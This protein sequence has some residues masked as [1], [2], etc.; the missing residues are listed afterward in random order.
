M[1][2]S[3]TADHF[4]TTNYGKTMK[5]YNKFNS[6]FQIRW[7][8]ALG[9]P[10]CPYLY[11]WTLIIF[12]FTI[13]LHHW[14]RSDDNRYF[15]DHAT[16]LISIILKGH[17]YNVIPADDS[18]DTSKCNKILVK[19][20]SVWKAKA[21]Q[22][23]YLEIPEGGA[24]TLL[25]CGRPYNKWGFWVP[26]KDNGVLRKLRPLRYFHEYGVIQDEDYQ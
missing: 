8:E 12:G 19:A 23:H 13:R 5:N 3:I 2:E 17:Y 14:L 10:E 15:H 25:L 11:R 4:I 18:C 22:R 21:E 26:R 6:L 16:N 7:K 9:K 24:W 20:G 1:F